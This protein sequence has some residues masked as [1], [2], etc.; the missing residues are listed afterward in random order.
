[1]LCA[2]KPEPDLKPDQEGVGAMRRNKK[3]PKNIIARQCRFPEGRNKIQTACLSGGGP[4]QHNT[5]SDT[6]QKCVKGVAGAHRTPPRFEDRLRGEQHRGAKAPLL[7]QLPHQPL[8]PI[9]YLPSYE[10]PETE[11]QV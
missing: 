11:S 6:P 10:N 9:T 2:H 1:M 3:K 7:L 8:L 5:A 4:Y